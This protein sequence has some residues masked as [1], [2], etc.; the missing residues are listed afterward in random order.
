MVDAEWLAC[1]DEGCQGARVR[2]TLLAAGFVIGASGA[3][4]RE[5]SMKTNTTIQS[6]TEAPG[7]RDVRTRWHENHGHF[8]GKVANPTRVFR[9]KGTAESV[10]DAASII[11]EAVARYNELCEDK[12]KG[13][14]VRRTQKVRDVEFSYQ[15]PP[16]TASAGFNGGGPGFGV[17][18]RHGS[19]N[20]SVRSQSGNK[21]SYNLGAVGSAS[22]PGFFPGNLSGFG[23]GN[24]MNSNQLRLLQQQLAQMAAASGFSHGFGGMSGMSGG[25]GGDFY[26]GNAQGNHAQGNHPQGNHAQGYHPQAAMFSL[27]VGTD[28]AV[29]A[30]AAQAAAHAVAAAAA[31]R[32]GAGGQYAQ[33][34]TNMGG[35]MGAAGHRGDGFGVA[36]RTHR[37][38]RGSSQHLP[39]NPSFDNLWASSA[40]WDPSAIGVHGPVTNAIPS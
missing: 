21:E 40:Q 13:E 28:P 15:P 3:S 16:K 33:P 23:D 31:N 38:R 36:P 19:F 29:V 25:M 27:P 7:G 8:S 26:H 20:G 5:L 6:W 2:V 11:C 9:I 12:K 1:D 24:T 35:G 18:K 14:F 32:T 30:A 34:D 4:V 10:S 37:D 17:G 22:A 39:S